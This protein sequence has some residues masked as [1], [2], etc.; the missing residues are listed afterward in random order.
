MMYFKDRAGNL[1]TKYTKEEIYS[2]INPF[3]WD[4]ILPWLK[5]LNYPAIK[6]VYFQY[7]KIQ[8]KSNK[9]VKYTFDKYLALMN[10]ASY[11]AFTYEDDFT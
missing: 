8:Q 6:K 2:K 4:S 5:E 1:Y 11:K 9:D 10:L 3:D 7:L